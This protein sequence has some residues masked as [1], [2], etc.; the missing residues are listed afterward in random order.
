MNSICFGNLIMISIMAAAWTV[1]FFKILIFKMFMSTRYKKRQEPLTRKRPIFSV[2]DSLAKL[3]EFLNNESR[4]LYFFYSVKFSNFG[5]SKPL[6][7]LN[8]FYQT[9][10]DTKKVFISQYFVLSWALNSSVI[11]YFLGL[12]QYYAGS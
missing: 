10:R 11:P 5:N 8:R 9:G 4:Y 6:M 2:D 3:C 1:F 7:S 12:G